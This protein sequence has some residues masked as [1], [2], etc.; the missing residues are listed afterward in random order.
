MLPYT[1]FLVAVHA[2]RILLLCLKVPS[3]VS[4]GDSKRQKKK[5]GAK[6]EKINIKSAF[7]YQQ[8]AL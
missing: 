7:S 6:E 8:D 4:E 5:K 1:Y 3:D 2:Y